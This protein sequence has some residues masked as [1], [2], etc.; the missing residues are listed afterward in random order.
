MIVLKANCPGEEDKP[1]ELFRSFSSWLPAEELVGPGRLY[2]AVPR[3]LTAEQMCGSRTL[4]ELW[5]AGHPQLA[6]LAEALKNEPTIGPRL[7]HEVSSSGAGA[8]LASTRR[9]STA[10]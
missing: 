10:V 4:G 1:L 2:R 3:V 7:D 6:E 5:E 9:N 8:Y